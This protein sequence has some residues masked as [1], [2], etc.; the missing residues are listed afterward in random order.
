M[1]YLNYQSGAIE[2]GECI[3]GAWE[4]VKR[5]FGLYLGVGLM[6]MVL[7]GCIPIVSLFL[8]GPV[9]GGFA[10]IVLRD[11]RDEPVD[12]GMMFKGFEKFVPL[13]V[14]GLI[15]AIPAII[16]QIVQ[17]TV[18]IQGM[19]SGRTGGGRDFYVSD[20]PEFNL[21]AGFTAGIIIVFV[22]VW[23]FQMIWNAALT[24]AIPL[25]IEHDI[26]IGD[27]IKLSLGAVFSNLGGLIVLG[28]ISFFVA[29]L[30]ML[31]ICLGLFV[32]IPVI[33]AANV[34]AYR[35]VF[36][37]MEQFGGNLEPPPPNTYGN[38]GSGMQ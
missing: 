22:G 29:L 11:M 15:Q 38:F 33:Y 30:G 12:F 27:A 18:D 7:V 26:S 24:F 1:T 34:F 19:I 3:S 28:I 16:F 10:Y 9:M 35:Q 14:M 2:A 36:P 8:L 4:L 6:T 5:N 17:W 23:L 20:S 25:I 21:P 37:M 32:A 13:M 31:A